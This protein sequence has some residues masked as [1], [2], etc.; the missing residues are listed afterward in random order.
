[1]V[2]DVPYPGDF[3]SPGTQGTITNFLV[4]VG[5]VLLLLAGAS[6]FNEALEENIHA[7]RVDAGALPG[8]L[9]VLASAFRVGWQ[10]VV[11]TWAAIIPGETLAD[12]ALTPLVLLSFTGLIYGF[13]DPGFG[14]NHQ[15]LV[16]FVSIAISQ[17]VLVLVYEGGKAWLTRRTLHTDA[18][19]RMFPACILIALVSVSISRIGGFQPGFV[20]GFIAAAT[21]VGQPRFTAAERGRALTIISLVLL[22]VTISAWLLAIPLHD[23]YLANPNHWTALPTSIAMSIFVI[24][25]EGLLFSLIPLEFMDGFRIW[26]WNKLAWLGL[27]MPAAFLFAQVLFNEDGDPYLSLIQ[28]TRSVSALVVLGIYIVISFST[29]AYFRWRFE[30]QEAAPEPPAGATGG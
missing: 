29:W 24:C 27:F 14:F 26:K 15:S 7:L 11:R 5:L 30:D 21:V 6:L 16:I 12:R 19:I 17:G 3:F 22:G 8:P 1:M 13:L 18:R 20:I 23:L 4:A 28:S 10:A 25:L 2:E 9:A